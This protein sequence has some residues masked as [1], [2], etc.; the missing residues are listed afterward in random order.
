MFK[1]TPPAD[2]GY[3]LADEYVAAVASITERAQDRDA[4]VEQRLAALESE[5]HALQSLL[6]RLA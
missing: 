1:S 6:A 4:V 5:Q 3:T 2:T